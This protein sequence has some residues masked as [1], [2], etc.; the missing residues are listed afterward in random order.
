MKPINLQSG[1]TENILSSIYDVD[2]QNKYRQL[3]K[4]IMVKL[5]HLFIKNIVITRLTTAKLFVI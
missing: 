2:P 5:K 4:Q 1:V 3:N